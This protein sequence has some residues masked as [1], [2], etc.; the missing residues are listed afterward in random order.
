MFFFFSWL[1]LRHPF[2]WAS[3]VLLKVQ[4]PELKLRFYAWC[5]ALGVWGGRFFLM[6]R[7]D[8]SAIFW[9]LLG[10]FW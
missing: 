7:G 8:L 6:L 1:V 10:H 3:K 2:F 9:L 5:W 4:T